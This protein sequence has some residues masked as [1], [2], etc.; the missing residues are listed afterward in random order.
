MLLIDLQPVVLSTRKVKQHF[1]CRH[2][3]SQTRKSY[4]QYHNS[5]T[6][7]IS[8]T[9]NMLNIYKESKWSKVFC[10]TYTILHY[11][12]KCCCCRQA[13]QCFLSGPDAYGDD[14][15][16]AQ[17]IKHKSTVDQLKHAGEIAI[18]DW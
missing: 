1:N 4:V 6:F 18:G 9:E 14:W 8:R 12:K 17:I 7:N 10:F 11:Y 5:V 3:T 2:R 16:L 13:A 15:M